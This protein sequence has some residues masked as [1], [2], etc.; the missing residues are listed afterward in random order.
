M[1]DTVP[2]V[3]NTFIVLADAYDR[4]MGR[5]LPTLA[6]AF[7]AAAGVTGT[8][9]LLDV[10]CGPGGLT[11]ELVA[12][13]GADS[14][15]AVDPSP[16]FVEACRARNPG[17]DVR[18]AAAEQLPFA[19]GSFDATL[20]SLVVG[21]MTDA[22]AGVREMARVTTLGG[23]VAACF[24]DHAGMPSIQTFW[25]AAATIDAPRVGEVKRLGSS[26]GDLAALFAHAG[27]ADIEEQTL[28]ASAEYDGFEDWW[29]PFTLGVGPAGAY[30]QTL[31]S[32]QRTALRQVC[33]AMLGDP[34]GP[35]ALEGRAWFARG[36]V[37][38][39][40]DGLGYP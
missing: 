34:A 30:W 28:T 1:T 25:T 27:L 2:E 22:E 40:S 21:F 37:P 15:A 18:Q 6:P 20:A 5:Y 39:K 29:V 4:L 16:P 24:W 13:A 26:E 11:R 32:D 8:M 3:C 14:V 35:F 33:A 12:R 31:D 19:D 9:R 38:A 17:V 10:G 23:T 7:A 36:V